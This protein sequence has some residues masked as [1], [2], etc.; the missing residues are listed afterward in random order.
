MPGDLIADIY[1]PDTVATAVQR[2]ALTFSLSSS[3]EK[4]VVKIGAAKAI[5]TTSAKAMEAMA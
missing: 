3:T 1:A 5:E 4:V 2:R